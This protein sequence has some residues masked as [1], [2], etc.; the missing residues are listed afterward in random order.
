MPKWGMRVIKKGTGRCANFLAKLTAKCVEKRL[1]FDRQ[2]RVDVKLFA[3]LGVSKGEMRSV[4]EVAIKLELRR[5]VWDEMGGAV[6]SVTDDGMAEGLRVDADLVG[7]AS[8]DA[9]LDEGEG[10][11]WSGETFE[12]MEV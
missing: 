1:E 12:D 8:F 4:E 10:T 2:G 9:D 11:M 3:G 5:E 6:E 7:A